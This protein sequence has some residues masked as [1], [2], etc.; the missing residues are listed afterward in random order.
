MI[1]TMNENNIGNYNYPKQVFRRSTME[2]SGIMFIIILFPISE[3]DKQNLKNDNQN[4][5]F[6]RQDE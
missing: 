3:I 1:N 5:C 2:I 4:E 6:V